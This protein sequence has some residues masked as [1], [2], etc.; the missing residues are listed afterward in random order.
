M[1]GKSFSQAAVAKAAMQIRYYESNMEMLFEAFP[2]EL[3]TGWG[4]TKEGCKPD[5]AS[6]H[7][8]DVNNSLPFAH[9]VIPVYFSKTVLQF[10]LFD[11]RTNQSQL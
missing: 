2:P 7:R 6:H 11:R 10:S 5:F 3:T 9:G 8:D 1:F 4:T